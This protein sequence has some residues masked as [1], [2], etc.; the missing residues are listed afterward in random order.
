[1]DTE[2]V[3]AFNRPQWD[4]LQSF[5][6]RPAKPKS[7]HA[8][9]RAQLLHTRWKAP[10][11]ALFILVYGDDYF[12]SPLWR[13][14]VGLACV[15]FFLRES[16]P[17]ARPLPSRAENPETTHSPIPCV[18][19][20][21]RKAFSESCFGSSGRRQG[22]CSEWQRPD[23]VCWPRLLRRKRDPRSL[24]H[25]YARETLLYS[26]VWRRIIDFRAVAAGNC[27]EARN[28]LCCVCTRRALHP[29]IKGVARAPVSHIYW[30]C[31]RFRNERERLSAD[32][33][34]SAG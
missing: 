22:C 31:C 29:R 6:G 1:M 2:R 30:V 17:R 5:A 28:T 27:R 11:A 10:A 21:L 3:I 4:L 32:R 25:T 16:H 19:R 12:L 20:G 23:C 24:P 14:S 34:S 13:D 15:F 26:R 7:W 9:L 18:K 8:N 33:F